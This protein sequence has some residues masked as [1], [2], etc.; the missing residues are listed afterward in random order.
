[1]VRTY[2]LL[3]VHRYSCVLRGLLL[4]R[5][6]YRWTKADMD[7]RKFCEDES[8]HGDNNPDQE[9]QQRVMN[10]R[11]ARVC[12]LAVL[13]IGFES[14]NKFP[15]IS[16]EGLEVSDPF[17]YS[18]HPHFEPPKAFPILSH[19]LPQFDA[20]SSPSASAHCWP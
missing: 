9:S 6:Y 8:E 15:H 5:L 14:G 12:L 18:L 1:M 4:R 17:F 11:A 2:S 13:L 10:P 3:R 19:S 7:I 20:S 16:L